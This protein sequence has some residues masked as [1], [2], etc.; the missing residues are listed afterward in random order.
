MLKI[1][2]PLG[3]LIF[4]MGIA[5]PGKTVFLIETAPRAFTLLHLYNFCQW[6]PSP[7]RHLEVEMRKLACMLPGQYLARPYK[8]N[9]QFTTGHD[10]HSLCCSHY[11]TFINCCGKHFI[12]MM[13][14][15][16]SAKSE[17]HLTLQLHNFII[18]LIDYGVFWTD[19][20]GLG[21]IDS[22]CARTFV[23]WIQFGEN[24]EKY[25]GR[26]MCFFR[27]TTGLFQ[28]LSRNCVAICN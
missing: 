11:T 22:H 14:E 19:H 24:A 27:M 5:I 21:V 17:I 20:G 7:H 16:L 25:V 8:F 12:A 6:Q 4:N 1:R 28:I 3:R 9:L 2:R 18:A 23:C 10:R 15:W 13:T 26:T